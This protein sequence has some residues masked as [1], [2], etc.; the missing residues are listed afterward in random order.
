M[1]KALTRDVID[2]YEKRHKNLAAHASP[3]FRIE[4]GDT[5]TV[6]T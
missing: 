1:P 5:V 4:L 3:A 6:G 2:R